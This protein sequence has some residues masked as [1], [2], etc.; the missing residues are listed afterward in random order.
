MIRLSRGEMQNDLMLLAENKEGI[1]LEG[2]PRQRSL[3][4]GLK[5]K[6]LSIQ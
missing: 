2:Q 1:R 6:D 3:S 5:C 4:V